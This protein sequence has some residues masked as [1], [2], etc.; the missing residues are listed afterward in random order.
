M[1]SSPQPTSVANK[2]DAT[3]HAAKVDSLNMKIA[4]LKTALTAT[5]K[6]AFSVVKPQPSTL[7]GYLAHKRP[8]PHRTLQKDY[9]YGPTAVLGGGPF[10][11]SEVPLSTRSPEP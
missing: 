5:K 2:L 10:L 3:V 7:Q 8:Q 9:A 11:M 1:V 4:E 6:S